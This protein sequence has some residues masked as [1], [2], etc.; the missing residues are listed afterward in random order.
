LLNFS[1]AAS[2]FEFV[3]WKK[4]HK[5]GTFVAFSCT[6]VHL[7][8]LQYNNT[9]RA[10]ATHVKKTFNLKNDIQKAV[11]LLRRFER[12]KR[13]LNLQLNLSA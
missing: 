8:C 11:L 4:R 2:R 7:F 9:W 10:A 6:A 1:F 12:P 5:I 3:L 13:S